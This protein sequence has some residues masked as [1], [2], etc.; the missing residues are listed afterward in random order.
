MARLAGLEPAIYSL[1]GCC[2]IHSAIGAM[3]DT[4]GF[5]PLEAHHLGCLVDSCLKPLGHVSRFEEELVIRYFYLTV[6]ARLSSGFVLIELR[7]I[8][9]VYSIVKDQLAL[10]ACYEI[11]Y[12]KFSR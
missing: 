11:Y 5:E 9:F 10:S 1:E 8:I 6:E 12:I 7:S 3:A 4:S 2:L